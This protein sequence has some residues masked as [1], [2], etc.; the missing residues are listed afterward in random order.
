MFLEIVNDGGLYLLNELVL[1]ISGKEIVEVLKLLADPKHHP[2][3]MYCTAGG[4]F[5]IHVNFSS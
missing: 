4:S 3:A 2:V 1:E 5:A